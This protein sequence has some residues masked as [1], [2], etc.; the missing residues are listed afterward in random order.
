MFVFFV[1]TVGRF[2]LLLLTKK[3][4]LGTSLPCCT[5]LRR[6]KV[7]TVAAADAASRQEAGPLVVRVR[8]SDADIPDVLGRRVDLRAAWKIP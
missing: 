1:A 8:P 3:W 6:A 2:L 5:N 7:D 4:T